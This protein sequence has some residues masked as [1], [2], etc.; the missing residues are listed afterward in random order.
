M[1]EKT[2]EFAFNFNEPA[3]HDAIGKAQYV[4][5]SS[6]WALW[7][8]LR[9]KYNLHSLYNQLYTN[10]AIIHRSP[11]QCYETRHACDTVIQCD[12]VLNLK[13]CTKHTHKCDIIWLC[14]IHHMLPSEETCL[15]SIS[16]ILHITN[17]PNVLWMCPCFI[18]LETPEQLIIAFNKWSQSDH[19]P[20]SAWVIFVLMMEM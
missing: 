5:S 12:L 16:T 3:L 20:T 11:V 6:H 13:L 7:L 14:N 17:L 8:T 15:L 4:A 10:D 1:K 2:L 18:G 19:T 9:I